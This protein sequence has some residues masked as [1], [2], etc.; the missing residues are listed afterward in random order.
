MACL[1]FSVPGFSQVLLQEDFNTAATGQLTDVIDNNTGKPLASPAGVQVIVP[2]GWTI[3][4]EVDPTDVRA[5]NADFPYV[6]WSALFFDGDWSNTSDDRALAS[7]LVDGILVVDSRRCN[8]LRFK[9]WAVTPSITTTATN[10]VIEYDQ[11]Y[12]HYLN[13][14]SRLEVSW[15][16][17]KTWTTLFQYDTSFLTHKQNII[18]HEKIGLKVPAGSASVTLRF[19]FG[20]D[21]NQNGYTDSDCYWAIDNLKISNGGTSA[22]PG[23][24]TLTAAPSD[25][26]G[27]GDILLTGSTFSG[28][29][30]H[31]SSE[32]QVATD[33]DFAS[34]V[35]LSEDTKNLTS[36]KVPTGRIKMDIPV[37]AR[38]RYIDANGFAS[39]F[40]NVVQTSISAAAVGLVQIEKEDFESTAQYALPTGW[41]DF[42]FSADI[43]P[44]FTTWMVATAADLTG[45]RTNVP[46]YEGNSCY[47]T[48]DTWDPI[49]DEHLL[50]KR[51]T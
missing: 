22:A 37:F 49:Q 1:V 45:N 13:Q 35:Y 41:T 8:N 14:V 40:S 4:S 30:A 9:T 11:H 21:Q 39:D 32:W 12:R 51:I 7:G 5:A 47:C 23:A 2:A 36:T 48:S 31:T 15:D 33:K 18:S 29:A 19:F 17:K 38:V 6:G 28:S 26:K 50:S 24:P 27:I 42:N 3:T 44:D 43:G 16:G 34:I 46:V 20:G 25:P 10:I